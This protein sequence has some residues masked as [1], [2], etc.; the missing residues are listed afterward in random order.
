MFENNLHGEKMLP[1]GIE[2]YYFDE[3][4][5]IAIY[6]GDCYL[7]LPILLAGGVRPNLVLTDPPYGDKFDTDFTRF[8]G[9]ADARRNIYKSIHGDAQPFAPQFL[10]DVGCEVVMFGGNRFSNHLPVGSWIVWDK[11]TPGGNKNV[12]S[13]AEVAWWSRGRGVYIFEHTWDGF[14]RASERHTAYHPTQK[15]VALMRWCIEKT[16]VDGLVLDP[17]M[18]SG[19]TLRAAKDLGRRAIGIELEERYCE[20]AA[21]RLQQ[22]VLSLFEV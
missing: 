19:P 17:F 11:R 15:P 7:L 6:H 14:N 1:K 22:G 13:D 20:I 12:M 5:G 21:K 10:L 9:G 16:G 18:G 3:N 4:A 8:S 2:P